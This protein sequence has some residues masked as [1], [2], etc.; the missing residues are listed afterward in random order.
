MYI[1]SFTPSRLPAYP[2]TRLPAYPLTRPLTGMV[3]YSN[4]A[5]AGRC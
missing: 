1:G 2:L 4:A 3:V 5:S